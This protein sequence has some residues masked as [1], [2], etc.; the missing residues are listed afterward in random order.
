MKTTAWFTL[1]LLCIAQLARATPPTPPP[2]P[3]FVFSTAKPVK[4][5]PRMAAVWARLTEQGTFSALDTWTR[6]PA[7]PAWVSAKDAE[8]ETWTPPGTPAAMD[9]F[10]H[11]VIIAKDRPAIVVRTGGFAGVYQ[12]FQEKQSNPEPE[13]TPA[14]VTPPATPES[15]RP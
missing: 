8:C 7:F 15:R 6:L 14:P 4:P 10:S 13:P 9:M 11:T 1:L 5:S 2:E 3:Y 12:I